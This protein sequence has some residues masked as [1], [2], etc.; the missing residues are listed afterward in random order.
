MQAADR[1]AN[2]RSSMRESVVECK[3]SQLPV[4]RGRPPW[5]RSLGCFWVRLVLLA[6]PAG[7]C[8]GCNDESSLTPDGSPD[9]ASCHA[10]TPHP[11][12]SNSCTSLGFPGPPALLVDAF[13]VV[14]GDFN[15][16]GR[17]DLALLTVSASSTAEVQ[18]FVG[19]GAGGFQHSGTFA[20]GI[21]LPTST[22][23]PVAADIDG[24]GNTDVAIG[25]VILFGNG[26]ATL[27]TALDL[28]RFYSG[29][30][31]DIDGDGDLDLVRV[32]YG[33][34]VVGVSRNN[35]DR[36]FTNETTYTG[37]SGDELLEL[38]DVNGDGN[39]DVIARRGTFID[40]L[41]GNG[42]STLGSVASYDAG[43]PITALTVGDVTGD[44]NPDVIVVRRSPDSSLEAFFSTL[45]GA[46]DGTFPTRVDEQ[47][48]HF[49]L[50]FARDVSGDG[51]VDIL[52]THSDGIGSGFVVRRGNGD[53]SFQP[54]EMYFMGDPYAAL[55]ADVDGNGR[56]D[57]VLAH[58]TGSGRNV[59][60]I[61]ID[62]G[63]GDFHVPRRYAAVGVADEA[64]DFAA[65]DV[66]HDGFI[67]AIIGHGGNGGFGGGET[68][69][70]AIT[71]RLG[72]A[73]GSFGPRVDYNVAS[74]P[75]AIAVAVGD[76][77]EDGHPDIVAGYS[78]S[79]SESDG[80]L[81]ILS[82][83]GDGS[84]ELPKRIGG[85]LVDTPVRR[86]A[87]AD[88]DGDGRLDIIAATGNGPSVPYLVVLLNEGTAGTFPRITP[89][90]ITGA[91]F[92][93]DFVVHDVD[94]DCRKDV[95]VADGARYSIWVWRNTGSGA[96]VPSTEHPYAS[97]HMGV[98]LR[99]R[100]AVGDV[101]VDGVDDL[102]VS[103]ADSSSI[104]GGDPTGGGA[105]T[106]LRG[107]SGGAFAPYSDVATDIG[108]RSIAV[109]D[110]NGDTIPDLV[111]ADIRTDT[112]AILHGH[113]DR[114]F[115]PVR[116]F[117]TVNNPNALHVADVDLDGTLDVLVVGASSAGFGSTTATLS[118]SR[119]RC[120]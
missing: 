5:P 102:V 24:D 23:R 81:S 49:P 8:G 12:S 114:S 75:R 59:V 3:Y 27:Q 110:M 7:G 48:N 14:S 99:A 120:L 4:F 68:S 74:P 73:D 87:L 20:T 11:V 32:V 98:G 100:V 44:S 103:W 10:T 56:P 45:I 72:Q 89:Y 76:V 70:A 77:N 96:L 91:G 86:L 22:L 109:A 60:S 18:I 80:W 93:Q 13:D 64:G 53:G 112:L 58:G 82:G 57:V 16:D 118:V 69:L 116:R 63:N 67:D 83:R 19:T 106:V 1:L 26:D 40:M 61:A 71:V 66:N 17:P 95:V 39:L 88:L 115:E 111:V 104:G 47:H 97:D 30:Y 94:G 35:G 2:S 55:V 90:T 65:A 51:N 28:G 79:L 117:T 6:S 9:A 50:L 119:G 54:D 46:G 105:V 41:L 101:D 21:P 31:G 15:K 85:A 29:V 37:G 108:G 38:H 52:Y 113:V 42:D 43:G 107:T 25:G 92:P 84:F 34:A 36:T 33:Q 62:N 78:S